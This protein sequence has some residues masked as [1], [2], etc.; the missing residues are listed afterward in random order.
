MFGFIDVNKSVRILH[1]SDLDD[2]RDAILSDDEDGPD[3][4]TPCAR[5]KEAQIQGKRIQHID[6]PLCA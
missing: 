2:M 6:M 3:G 5:S 1:S 4:G